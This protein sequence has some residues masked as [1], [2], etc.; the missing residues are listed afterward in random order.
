MNICDCEGTYDS[1]LILNNN[2]S[3][4]TKLNWYPCKFPTQYTCSSV[5]LVWQKWLLLVIVLVSQTYSL[6]IVQSTK[7]ILGFLVLVYKLKVLII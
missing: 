2:I 7:V 6:V 5:V 4:G 3:L 1:T